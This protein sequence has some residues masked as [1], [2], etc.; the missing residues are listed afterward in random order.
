MYQYKSMAFGLSVAPRVFTKIMRYT[1]E[2]L[3]TK[4]HL[5]KLVFLINLEKSNPT[6]LRMGSR[7]I[8]NGNIRSL[9][10]RRNG[11][12]SKCKRTQGDLVCSENARRKISRETYFRIYRQYNRIEVFGKSRRESLTST[13]GISNRNS[14]G[15]QP[16]QYDSNIQSYTREIKHKGRCFKVERR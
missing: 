15:H 1:M 6:I 14:R 4:E 12:L 16:L 7:F 3:R 8:R 5:T 13:S 2:P 9:D 10:N 11:R